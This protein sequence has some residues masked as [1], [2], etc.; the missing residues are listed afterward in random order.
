MNENKEDTNESTWNAPFLSASSNTEGFSTDNDS[1]A[2]PILYMK[3]KLENMKENKKEEIK[4]NIFEQTNYKN[5]E[6]FETIHKKIHE[7]FQEPLRRKPRGLKW[8]LRNSKKK[9]KRKSKSKCDAIS[10]KAKDKKNPVKEFKRIYKEI[11]DW[12]AAIIGHNKTPDELVGNE[13]DKKSEKFISGQNSKW[14]QSRVGEYFVVLFTMVITFSTMFYSTETFKTKYSNPLETIEDI[15][16]RAAFIKP[17]HDILMLFLEDVLAPFVIL[18]NVGLNVIPSFC[19]L[20]GLFKT[21]HIMFIVL[22]GIFF[23]LMWA[24]YKKFDWFL[25]MFLTS[26]QWKM[27]TIMFILV[28]VYIF[29]DIVSSMSDPSNW[30]RTRIQF[31]ILLIKIV[32]RILIALFLVPISQMFFGFGFLL[33]FFI[34]PVFI[35]FFKKSEDEMTEKPP[36]PIPKLSDISDVFKIADEFSELLSTPDIF[37]GKFEEFNNII[38][39]LTGILKRPYIKEIKTIVFNPS[40]SQLVKLPQIIMTNESDLKKIPEMFDE[41]PG[42]LNKI[43]PSV[44]TELK[45]ILPDAESFRNISD[46]ESLTTNTMNV[47]NNPDLG[48]LINPEQLEGFKT[49]VSNVVKILDKYKTFNIQPTSITESIDL[50][51]KIIT[52]PC[53]DAKDEHIPDSA[54]PILIGIP[55]L[56]RF[57]KRK[58]TENTEI[59]SDNITSWVFNKNL[60]YQPN[61]P[62]LSRYSFILL[63]LFRNIL[64][65]VFFIFFVTNL[66]DV[67][68]HLPN[69]NPT[70]YTMYALFNTVIV[71]YFLYVIV[72]SFRYHIFPIVT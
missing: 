60:K 44:I 38:T 63:F 67:A 13:T 23:G 72:M 61:D 31:I 50:I 6:L 11:C 70:F 43:D 34:F 40:M 15:G 51:K 27:N 19:N 42:K 35:I 37:V 12:V 20:S 8:K 3:Q 2:F 4:Q 22:F 54:F 24:I 16:K 48:K 32:I 52:A 47:I 45:G 39:P 57:S 36:P 29:V 62:P 7:P 56:L 1:T 18:L 9:M 66:A 65:I 49:I 55:T 64:S 71:V 68:K 5:I 10:Q 58:I 33:L 41:I 14:L 17:I 25:N 28:F 59:V 53:V 21:P 30:P 69:A 46:L 26:F